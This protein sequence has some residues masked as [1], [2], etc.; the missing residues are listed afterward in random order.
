MTGHL[1]SDAG[2]VCPHGMHH[3]FDAAFLGYSDL[4][5]IVQTQVEQRPAPLYARQKLTQFTAAVRNTGVENRAEFLFHPKPTG[6][7]SRGIREQAPSHRENKDVRKSMTKP[8]EFKNSRSFRVTWRS[9]AHG[10]GHWN[11][12]T[13]GI[14]KE[15]QMNVARKRR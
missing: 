13:Q 15:K 3:G 6:F 5:R 8:K 11:S 1:D 9:E 2:S 14:E 7:E 4:P 10:I 12:V